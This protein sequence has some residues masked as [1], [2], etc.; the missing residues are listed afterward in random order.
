[1]ECQ[2]WTQDNARTRLDVT[3]PVRSASCGFPVLTSFFPF[4]EARLVPQAFPDVGNRYQE[5]RQLR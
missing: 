2:A 5:K 4:T 1:M 3:F